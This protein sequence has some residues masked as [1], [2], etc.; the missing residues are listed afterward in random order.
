MENW[1]LKQKYKY[2]VEDLD[3]SSYL[4]KHYFVGDRTSFFTEAYRFTGFELKLA[5]AVLLK[6]NNRYRVYKIN[7]SE[8]E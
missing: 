2:I 8:K 6:P 7:E 4:G 3:K 1:E 5:S